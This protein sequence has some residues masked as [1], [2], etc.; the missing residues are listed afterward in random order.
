MQKPLL[1]CDYL[2]PAPFLALCREKKLG[3]ELQSYFLPDFSPNIEKE[4]ASL[5]GIS[6]RGIH[7]PFI[8]LCP[9]SADS[10]IR[11]VTANRFK[12]ALS[13][14]KSL[15][16]QHVVFHN[17]FYPQL[18]FIEGWVDRAVTFW[19]ELLQDHNEG[20]IC[21]IENTLER[22]PSLFAEIVTRVAHPKF[23]INFDIGHAHCFSGIS[24]LVWVE[25][26]KDLIGYVHIHSNDGKSDQ[27]IS[28]AK[29]T[30]PVAET[31]KALQQYAPNATWAVE[32]WGEAATRE[33][34]DCLQKY[35]F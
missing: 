21:Y 28:I 34:L 35:G 22:D 10:E 33:S 11:T 18:H 20:P 5:D 3:I 4:L 14:A 13:Q 2:T 26:L 6:L 30:A 17:S 31:L 7:A 16:C 27:H 9:G 15:H 24:P 12:K 29:G 8:D 1:L 23:K 19:K 32:T 25:K